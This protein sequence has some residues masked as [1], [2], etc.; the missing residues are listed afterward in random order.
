GEEISIVAALPQTTRG[1]TRGIYTT[2]TMQL[3]FVDTPGVHRG[4]HLLNRAM[5][6]EA[7][8]AITDD[9]DL[10]CWLVDLSREYGDEEAAVADLVRS[11][12]GVPVLIVFN[13]IDL[14]DSA[15]NAV[16]RF[17]GVFPDL[18]AL[19]SLRLSAIH[20][21]AKQR[22]LAAVDP[23]IPEGPRYFDPDSVTDA[24]M[25]R[26]AAEQIR[27]QVIIAAGNE[28]PHATFVEI[29]SYR[30]TPRRHEIVATI[31]VETRGQRGIIVGKG[32]SVISRIKK[33]ARAGIMNFAGVP[34]SLTCHVK[35]SPHWRDNE[36]FLR[37]IGFEWRG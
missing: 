16:S 10:I 11:A 6:R 28:V 27:K 37:R 24:P 5:F 36:N 30:E 26:I 2:N 17:K 19:P 8:R 18:A 1:I 25:R 31:H 33:G 13:K 12:A 22:F 7:C 21:D 4:R 35:V 20:A 32:G 29:E 34:V 23:F 15:D 3:V 14:T 9:V